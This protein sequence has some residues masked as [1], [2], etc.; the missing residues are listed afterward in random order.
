M[1][2]LSWIVVGLITGWLTGK[3]LTG[4]G[5]GPIMDIVNGCRRS[6]RRWLHSVLHRFPGVRW[7]VF[8]RP[9]GDVWCGHSHRADCL[10]RRQEVVCMTQQ[11]LLYAGNGTQFGECIEENTGAR[12]S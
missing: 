2:F 8:H 6:N 9:S 3:A 11:E 1:Y 7:T 5:Y 4:G 10:C 12:Q